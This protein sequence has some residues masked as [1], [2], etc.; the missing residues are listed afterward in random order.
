MKRHNP[1]GLSL[2]GGR[3]PARDVWPAWCYEERKGLE[4]FADK[5]G[6][7]CVIPWRYIRAALKRKDGKAT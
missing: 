5:K 7:I 2:D 1:K 4:L 3:I 6:R